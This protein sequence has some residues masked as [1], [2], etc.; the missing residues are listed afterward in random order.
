MENYNSERMQELRK[1]F[2]GVQISACNSCW[3]REDLVGQSRR[4][5]FDKKFM[6]FD[7]DDRN[8]NSSTE[9]DVLINFTLPSRY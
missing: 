6:R 2:K 1:D 7:A 5:W 8:G 9:Y 3:E 4:L